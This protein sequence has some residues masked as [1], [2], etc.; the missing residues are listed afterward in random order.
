MRKSELVAAIIVFVLLLVSSILEV[1]R[2]RAEVDT[3]LSDFC[4][5][6]TGQ[7]E[8]TMIG[9]VYYCATKQGNWAKL[10]RGE[11]DES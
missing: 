7:A 3:L 4:H 6:Q 11:R 9:D 1:N 5:L 10:K 8:H 2:S